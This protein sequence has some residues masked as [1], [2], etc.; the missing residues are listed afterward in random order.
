MDKKA[1]LHTLA[2]GAM[3][4]LLGQT[5]FQIPLILLIPAFFVYI[6]VRFGNVYLFACVVMVAL[7][8]SLL[9]S[10][11]IAA[12]LLLLALPPTIVITYLHTA[13]KASF[14]A[15]AAVCGSVLAGPLLVVVAVFIYTGKDIVTAIQDW[16]YNIF[17]TSA[18][19]SEAYA[20]MVLLGHFDSVYDLF[21]NIDLPVFWDAIMGK[22]AVDVSHYAPRAVS[23]L[24]I[25]ISDIAPPLIIL[26]SL[27][28]GLFGFTV[29]RAMLIRSGKTLAP[30]PPFRNWE[31]PKSFGYGSLATLLVLYIGG[32]L[33]FSGFSYAFSIAL[34]LFMLV[35][36]VQGLALFTFI[37]KKLNVNKGLTVIINV[38]AVLLFMAILSVLGFGEQL[39]RLRRRF[40]KQA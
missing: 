21:A 26:Y 29:S 6:S 10:P 33:K 30:A 39:L 32:E 18:P 40:K 3:V 8:I 23:A 38:F 11:L 1:V 12:F 17:I 34:I 15:L 37:Q 14:H 2:V 35:Y 19:G 4:V 24:K 36:A 31:L 20:N 9:N 28:G 13:K 5:L 25:I 7:G 16:A 27:T 22:T